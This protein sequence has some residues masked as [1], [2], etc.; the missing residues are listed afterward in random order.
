MGRNRGPQGVARLTSR[1]L[2]FLL[3]LIDLRSRGEPVTETKLMQRLGIKN[4]SRAFIHELTMQLADK[5]LVRLH[6]GSNSLMPA[7]EI[8]LLDN[9]PVPEEA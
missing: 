2:Q 7:C 3:V 8:I 4:S 6:R 9:H 1:E 5:Q